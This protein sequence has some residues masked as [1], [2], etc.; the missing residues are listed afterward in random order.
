M[1]DLEKDETDIDPKDLQLKHL[2]DLMLD[3]K[4]ERFFSN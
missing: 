1:A 2:E 3:L 4:N